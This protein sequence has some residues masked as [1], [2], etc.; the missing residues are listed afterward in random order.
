MLE[1]RETEEVEKP[2][3]EEIEPKKE[4]DEFDWV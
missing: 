3:V 1:E 4:Q 2:V